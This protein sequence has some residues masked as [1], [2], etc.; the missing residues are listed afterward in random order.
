MSELLVA[1]LD[2]SR[3]QR[4]RSPASALASFCVSHTRILGVRYEIQ[5]TGYIEERYFREFKDQD[6]HS[7]LELKLPPG[8]P[9]NIID[10]F[11]WR[12][13]KDIEGLGSGQHDSHSFARYARGY[14]SIPTIPYDDDDID[15][16]AYRVDFPLNDPGSLTAGGYYAIADK[17]YRPIHSFI[18]LENGQNMSVL[19]KNGYLAI[20]DTTI[21]LRQLGGAFVVPIQH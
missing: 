21:L 2:K 9:G 11:H 1:Y 6:I 8:M 19:E 4:F 16:M 12:F 14:E 20:T 18:G 13:D 5:K 3:N 10:F 7:H 15:I 17:S